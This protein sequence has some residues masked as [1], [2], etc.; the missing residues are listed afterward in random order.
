M[1]VEEEYARLRKLF[2]EGT[3]EKLLE[4]VDGVLIEAARIRVEL[5][6]LNKI[7]QAGGLVKIDPANPTRQ[8][9]LPVAR[10]ITQVRANYLNYMAKI[11]K[12]LGS[13]SM[14]EEEDDFDEY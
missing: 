11:A 2:E 10:A 5:D 6:R 9:Q 1:E 3:D 7:A 14:D 13:G 8:K 12:M 4:A